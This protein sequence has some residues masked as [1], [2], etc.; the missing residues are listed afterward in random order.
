MMRAS[1]AAEQRLSLN[2]TGLKRLR[3]S[4]RLPGVVMGLNQESD[5]IHINPTSA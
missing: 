5:M 3:R 2:R 1:F 4:G